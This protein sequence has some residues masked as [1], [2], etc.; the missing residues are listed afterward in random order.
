MA[1]NQFVNKV[2][3]GTKE[4]GSENVLINL[5]DDT[6]IAE[7]LGLGLKAHN[8]TGAPIEGTSQLT[9][10]KYATGTFASPGTTIGK[11][12]IT[13]IGFKPK[14]FMMYNGGAI[15]SGNTSAPYNLIGA[16]SIYGDDYV[17]LDGYKYESHVTYF[18]LKNS[19]SSQPAQG[20][21]SSGNFFAP[22]E[23]GMQGNGTNVRMASGNSYIWFAWA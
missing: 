23:D 12:T 1:E 14:V 18:V 10:T 17:P 7:K 3:Y 9:I 16:V 19:S 4:D 6:V 21:H 8:A 5:S 13:S 22:I 20:G 15:L 11:I 2:V